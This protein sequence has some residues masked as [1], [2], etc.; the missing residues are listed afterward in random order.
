[1]N[2]TAQMSCQLGKILINVR[3]AKTRQKYHELLLFRKW[4]E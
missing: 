1:M 2:N 3:H 4:K